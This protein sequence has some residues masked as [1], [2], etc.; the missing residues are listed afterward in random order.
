MRIVHQLREGNANVNF[1]GWG[2]HFTALAGAMG[3]DL[4]GTLYRPVPTVNKRANGRSGLMI[5]VETPSIDNLSGFDAQRDL[6]LVGMKATDDLRAW[7]WS[8]REV[9]KR[10]A[11][12]VAH[13]VARP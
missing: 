2:D 8:H 12:V 6:I 10:W 3:T 9:I 4:A 7:I 1:Y 13:R 11:A 5:V